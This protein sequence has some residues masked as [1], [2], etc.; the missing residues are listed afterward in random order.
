MHFLMPMLSLVAGA[1]A[2]YTICSANHGC[3]TTGGTP[4]AVSNGYS[5]TVLTPGS[6]GCGASSL[7]LELDRPGVARDNKKFLCISPPTPSACANQYAS[8]SAD[9]KGSFIVTLEGPGGEYA[10]TSATTG[11][12][13]QTKG[14]QCTTPDGT[15][16]AAITPGSPLCQGTGAGPLLYWGVPGGAG[17]SA[18]LVP[19]APGVY[20]QNLRMQDENGSDSFS[21]CL[22]T[23]ATAA[24]AA[25]E[26]RAA[27][28]SAPRPSGSTPCAVGAA[29]CA[30]SGDIMTINGAVECCRTGRSMSWTNNACACSDPVSS[31]P[32]TTGVAP[33]PSTVSATTAAAVSSQNSRSSM[34]EPISPLVVGLSVAAATLFV[35]AVAAALIYCR[36][37]RR[38]AEKWGGPI[39]DYSEFQEQAGGHVPL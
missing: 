21:L 36:C 15:R 7:Y 35:M 11:E 30:G 22:Y 9:F 2:Q 1:T 6:T 8:N 29:A 17:V 39:G 18:C 32:T 13:C 34:M 28:T 33:T 4:C 10:V 38:A 24:P 23:P 14:L 16:L 27:A 37:R 3:C 31:R 12:A 26:T 20:Y 25:P 5:F 19:G